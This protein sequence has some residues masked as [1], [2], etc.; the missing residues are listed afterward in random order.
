MAEIVVLHM[1][2]STYTAN[3]SSD[4]MIQH[5]NILCHLSKI[6]KILQPRLVAAKMDDCLKKGADARKYAIALGS[7]EYSG[8][9]SK[10][11]LAFSDK[12]EKVF[13]ILQ[14]LRSRKVTDEG[15]FSKYFRIIDDKLAWYAKAE[16]FV[17]SVLSQLHQH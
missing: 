8:D 14:D 4:N 2:A 3:V 12:M 15:A 13:K 16:A 1:S 10:Q 9:L 11:L 5:T 7:L 17:F 6:S